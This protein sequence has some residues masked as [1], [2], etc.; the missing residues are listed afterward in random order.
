MM[1]AVRKIIPRW[2]QFRLRPD[3]LEVLGLLLTVTGFAMAWLPLGPIL[4]GLLLVFISQG[5]KKAT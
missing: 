3:W 1:A 5:M 2:S 4:G